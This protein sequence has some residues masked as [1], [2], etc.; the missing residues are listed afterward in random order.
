V[1]GEGGMQGI[2]AICRRAAIVLSGIAAA[3]FES[4]LHMAWISYYGG[5]EREEYYTIERRETRYFLSD[6]ALLIKSE[7]DE[8]RI[9]QDRIG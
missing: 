5:R 3:I 9:V 2:G 8:N 1:E 4:E 7:E 6:T